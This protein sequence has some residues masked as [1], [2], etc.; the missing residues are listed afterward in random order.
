[1]TVSSINY[2]KLGWDSIKSKLDSI[3]SLYSFEETK[4]LLKKDN[5]YKRFFGKSK[6]RTLINENPILYKSIYYHSSILEKA[7]KEQKT[8]K[9]SYNFKYRMIF[10]VEKNGELELLRCRCGKNYTWNKYCRYCPDYHKTFLGKSHSLETKKKQRLS[11]LKNIEK[12]S[13]K[14]SP[15]YNKSSIKLI[16]DYGKS[17]GLS[18]KHAENGGEFYIKELGYFVDAYDK[19]NNVVLEVDEK[20]HYKNGRLKD[21]DV[22]RQ[23]EIE[24]LL[25]C[26]F[27]RLKI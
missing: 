2:V 6:N 3:E 12:L 1:M 22:K 20:R 18:F 21:S 17:N 19:T 5:F 15:R 9:G 8:Y 7:L 26:K 24:N 10:I 14:V 13:G 16:E 4:R 23:R 27:V 25:K 11:A